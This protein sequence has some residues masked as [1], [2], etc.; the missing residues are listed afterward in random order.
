MLVE[1][2]VPENVGAVARAMKT[3]GFYDLLLVNPCDHLSGPARWLAH[4]SAEILEDARIF[5]SVDRAVAGFDLIIG[6]T[7]KRRSVKNDYYNLTELPA[8][9]HSKGDTVEKAVVVFGREESG[10]HNEEL[11]MCDFVTTIPMKTTFPS[12]NLAQAVMLYSW[13]LSKSRDLPFHDRKY[14]QENSLKVLNQKVKTVLLETG[15]R[16]DSAIFSR[17]FERINT[18]SDKDIN[19]I[20]SFCNKFLNFKK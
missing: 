15:F 17:Y 13:E 8:M 20:H 18:L 11:K 3:M 2:A 7:A 10:L 16:E 6:T 9:L 5:S 4:G 14:L 19:L 12:L 1:P